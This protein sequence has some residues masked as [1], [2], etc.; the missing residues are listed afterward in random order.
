MIQA[1]AF[2]RLAEGRGT[3]QMAQRGL[4]LSAEP[5]NCR[6]RSDGGLLRRA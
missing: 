6:V 5:Q 3:A 2:S 1:S 4:S